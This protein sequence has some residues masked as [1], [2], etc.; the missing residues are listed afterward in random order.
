MTR[1]IKFCATGTIGF[2]VDA[3]VLVF[4]I[5]IF[6]I[7][8][9]RGFSFFV[10]F[11][12]T[13]VINRIWTFSDVRSTRPAQEWSRYGA[14]QV[15]GAL[16]NMSVYAG[17]ILMFPWAERYPVLSLAVGSGFGMVVNFTLARKVVFK[18]ANPSADNPVIS[19]E[20]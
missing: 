6:G 10:A 20:K 4:L 18:G 7:F 11:T 13:W 19:S 9:A 1:F 17:L 15:L 8:G 3:S 2:G 16:T 12:V 14:V 5:P